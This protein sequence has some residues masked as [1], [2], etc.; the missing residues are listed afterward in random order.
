VSAVDAK[1][2]GAISDT[3]QTLPDP[4]QPLPVTTRLFEKQLLIGHAF[5]SSHFVSLDLTELFQFVVHYADRL[6]QFVPFLFEPDP[7]LFV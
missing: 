4:F 2:E 7:M 1:T 6:F 3:F 5:G